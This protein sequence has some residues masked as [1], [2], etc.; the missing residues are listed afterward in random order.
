LLAQVAVAALVE[1]QV[2]VAVVL[3]VIVTALIQKLLEAVDQAK[4][5]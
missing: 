5:P 4:R 1:R 3:V 2:Q